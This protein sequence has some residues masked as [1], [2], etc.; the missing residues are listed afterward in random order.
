MTESILNSPAS[1]KR[2]LRRRLIS[3]AIFIGVCMLVSFVLDLPVR[4]LIYRI[5]TDDVLPGDATRQIESLKEF[6]QL[7]AVVVACLLIFMLDKPRR[8][9]IPRL[10]VCIVL[11]LL[12]LVLPGKLVIHRL[13]P[14]TAM[15]YDTIWNLGFFWGSN[16]RELSIN[17][18]LP[19]LE[20]IRPSSSNPE[21]QS[22]PSAHTAVAFAFATG[23]S[24]IYP[25]ARPLFYVLAAGC[26]AHRIF[27]G[28]HWLSDVVA[29]V[30]I[31][32]LASRAV[33]RWTGMLICWV[34]S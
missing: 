8:G 33:W 23:L 31:G 15:S 16:P 18:E 20:K 14:A 5:N 7:V 30:F 24:A 27:F 1:S 11:P 17:P 29:S 3:W 19:S 26:G 2:N 25:A 13:R 21:K 32:I 28:A 34:R 12:T 9:M 4:S 10:V 6:G 22:F